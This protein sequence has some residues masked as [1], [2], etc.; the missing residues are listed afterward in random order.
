MQQC[1]QTSITRGYGYF[2]Q[3]QHWTS[4]PLCGGSVED[5]LD[6]RSNPFEKV[7]VDVGA[8]PQGH[9]GDDQV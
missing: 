3:V 4:K 8:C 1:L 9:A 2:S 5:P 6:L 7:E